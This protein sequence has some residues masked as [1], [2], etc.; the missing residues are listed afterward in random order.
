MS[1]VFNT[2]LLFVA[3]LK[4]YSL[5]WWRRQDRERM[6]ARLL[7]GKSGSRGWQA[8]RLGQEAG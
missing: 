2:H 6:L 8:E 5:S 4:G 3:T 7:W 1:C